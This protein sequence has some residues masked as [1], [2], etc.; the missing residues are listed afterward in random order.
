MS[1][2]NTAYVVQFYYDQDNQ[3]L[4]KKTIPIAD[5]FAKNPEDLDCNEIKQFIQ[6]DGL[7][8]HYARRLKN[9][10]KAEKELWHL[11]NTESDNSKRRQ[12]LEDIINMQSIIANCYAGVGDILNPKE[13][14]K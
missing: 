9:L 11:Y 3:L 10:E 5:S 8:P 14:T 2:D 6:R 12:I 4:D 13:I 7:W 1:R